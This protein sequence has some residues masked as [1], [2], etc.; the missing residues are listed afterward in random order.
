MSSQSPN[1]FISDLALWTHLQNPKDFPGSDLSEPQ[2][3]ILIDEWTNRCRCSRS[4]LSVSPCLFSLCNCEFQ[5]RT[6]IFKKPLIKKSLWNYQFTINNCKCW[7]LSIYSS[8]LKNA[9][10]NDNKSWV[11]LR[12]KSK[13]FFISKLLIYYVQRH[14]SWMSQNIGISNTVLFL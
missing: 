12:S 6:Y 14:H 1:Y 5:I 8:T 10:S 7:I 9:F 3:L 11:C 4:S 13:V 2:P